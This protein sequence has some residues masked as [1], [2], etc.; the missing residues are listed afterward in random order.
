MLSPLVPQIKDL[1]REYEIAGKGK[2][3]IEFTDP[4]TDL[5]TE[6]EANQKYG[7]RPIP[8]Q[9]ADRYQSAIVN[10]Y[11]HILVGY[12]EEFEVLNFQD[13]IETRAQ[14]DKDF[15]I[16]LRNPEYDLTRSIK[17]VLNNFRSGGNIFDS[18]DG[19]L[20]L[21]AYIS[22]DSLLP[23]DL[24][25]HKDSIIQIA[26]ELIAESKGMFNLNIIDPYEDNSAGA[27]DLSKL[28]GL[29]PLSLNKG[30]AG[31]FYYFHLILEKD[32]M[33]IQVPLEDK[34]KLSLERNFRAAI[35]RFG[36]GFTKTVG[37]IGPKDDPKLAQI[38]LTVPQFTQ[39]ADFLGTDLN[40]RNE[41]IT[42]GS[43]SGEIDTLLITAP[44]GMGPKE[45]F[46]IDQFLMKGG[47]VIAMSSP[48]T[49]TL[50]QGLGLAKLEGEFKDW[51]KHH[52]LSM[53]EK[54]VLDTQNKAFPLPIMRKVGGNQVQEVRMIEYPYFADIRKDG[55]NPDNPITAN[56]EQVTMAWSSPIIID[57]AINGDREI[58]ELMKSSKKSW[59]SEDTEIMPV[60][61]ND[62]IAPFSI[63]GNFSS[64]LLGVATKGKFSSYFTGKE[65]PVTSENIDGEEI[66]TSRDVLEISPK[67]SQIIL[68]SS[69]DFLRDQTLTIANSAIGSEYRGSMDL[70]ANTIDWALE[71]GGLLSIRSRG[72]FNRT[73][74]SI[75]YDIQLFW[76]Y[77]NYGLIIIALVFIALVRGYRKRIR[78]N[79]YLLEL[80]L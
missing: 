17:K 73:L 16:V 28:Y 68:F 42:D 1:I 59:L 45:V 22:D 33:A 80:T 56:L 25:S 27:K 10:S 77:L 36:K 32:D 61:D 70:I 54:L 52:G 49:M 44:N 62:G 78:K 57:T 35:K 29:Q 58:I 50:G 11:F 41:D 37:I 18:I 21:N 63:I 34:T 53:E 71:D 39:L 64:H 69:N 26:D 24:V 66:N 31:D 6:E 3:R 48:Y 74:P 43:V 7:V 47:S 67:T 2:I 15:E 9:V 60:I 20:T 55:F 65:S 12:G 72:Q 23:D 13:L 40:I 8:L 79:H 14:G 30:Y 51:L 76:E 19:K 38:G 75:D 4:V 5:Q 46:A